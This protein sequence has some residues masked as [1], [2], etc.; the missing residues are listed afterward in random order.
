MKSELVST[1]LH[2]AIVALDDVATLHTAAATSI[3]QGD[4]KAAMET[5]SEAFELWANIQ[6]AVALS[7]EVLGVALDGL[8]DDPSNANLAIGRAQR[9]PAFDQ[10]GAPG[11]RPD[12]IVRHLAIRVAGGRRSMARHAQRSRR[13]DLH[14]KGRDR[15]SPAAPERIDE[16]IDELMDKATDALTNGRYFETERIADRALR[17]ASQAAEFDRMARIVLPLMEARRLRVQEALA[18][19]RVVVRSDG[20]EEDEVVEPGCYLLQPPLVGADARRLRLSALN[21]ETPVF[22]V[23]REPTTQLGLVPIVGLG[24]GVVIRCHVQPPD[25]GDDA[26][27][28]RVAGRCP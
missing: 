26:P 24:Q 22:V 25:A 14:T 19:E 17:M 13:T 28:P 20:I 27:D 23:C 10:G 6:R 21:A 4:Q 8:H 15:M 3:E 18:T 2:D 1:T 9:A 7:T 12:P 5:L 11:T 16:R